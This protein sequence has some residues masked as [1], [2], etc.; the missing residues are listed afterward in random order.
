[1]IVFNCTTLARSVH[2]S[3]EPMTLKCMG[4]AFQ[5]KCSRYLFLGIKGYLFKVGT[6]D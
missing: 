3:R 4:V 6:R 2:N 1:M 5:D